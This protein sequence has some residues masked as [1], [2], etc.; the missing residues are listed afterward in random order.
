MQVAA[1]MYGDIPVSKGDDDGSLFS[2]LLKQS[3]FPVE[4]RAKWETL[5]EVLEKYKVSLLQTLIYGQPF[6]VSI[7]VY[8]I[9]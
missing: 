8:T 6:T 7:L 4:A 1:E 3:R 5:R 2:T 9:L